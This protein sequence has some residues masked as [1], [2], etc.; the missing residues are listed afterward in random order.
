[1]YID[2][3]CDPYIPND[4]EHSI[5]SNSLDSYNEEK[6]KNSLETDFTNHTDLL[7]PHIRAALDNSRSIRNKIPMIIEFLNDF[8]IDILIITE[9]WLSHKDCP[10]L[11]SL[12]IDP[13]SFSYLP[14]SLGMRGGGLGIL[15]KSSL[16]ISPLIDH[17][18][19]YCEAFSC[20]V[21][22]H[23]SRTFNISVFYHSPNYPIPPFLDEFN[24][25][26]THPYNSNIILRDFN[27]PI[28]LISKYS[29]RITNILNS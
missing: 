22:S 17:R 28:N 15:Y 23:R 16:H 29:T 18:H 11:S 27:I 20:S 5:W 14:R 12:N 10:L 1:M 7:I 4:E 25:F 6:Q 26:I 19:V 3:K 2:W 8:N 9:T 13:Y 24:N 21:S